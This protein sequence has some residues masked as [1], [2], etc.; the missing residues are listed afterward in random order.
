MFSYT[1]F[2]SSFCILENNPSSNM[3]FS[4]I[5]SHSV[6]LLFILLMVSFT[7]QKFFNFNDIQPVSSFFSWTVPLASFTHVL[8]SPRLLKWARMAVVDWGWV[9]LVA[10]V[11]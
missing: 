2:K 8:N 9:F 10:H 6:S 3:P 4:Y 7:E 11:S 5:F 1:S